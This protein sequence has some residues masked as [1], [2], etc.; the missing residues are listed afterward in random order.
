MGASGGDF[1]PDRVSETVCTLIPRTSKKRHRH[2]T[3]G[4]TYILTY[5]HTYRWILRLSVLLKNTDTPMGK[6][7]AD[8]PESIQLPGSDRRGA[9]NPRK[10]VSW[11]TVVYGVP[12]HEELH[13]MTG[14]NQ[15]KMSQPCTR[16]ALKGAHKAFCFL[17]EV[18]GTD[19]PSKFTRSSLYVPVYTELL[20]SA[21]P[22]QTPL[23]FSS[24]DGLSLW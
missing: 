19:L 3:A 4:N 15:L 17:E 2:T 14:Y 21:L 6:V 1:S 18:A 9:T 5:I 16:G 7:L 8:R 11:L 12:C 13:N 22:R 23:I 24:G 10:F 20:S